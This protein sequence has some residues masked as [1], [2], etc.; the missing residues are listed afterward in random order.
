[1]E[2]DSKAFVLEEIQKSVAKFENVR[3]RKKFSKA[4]FFSTRCVNK[5]KNRSGF[6]R[7]Y[8]FLVAGSLVSPKILISPK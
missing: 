5:I 1:M 8:Q 2:I 7:V 4:L 6:M 3:N